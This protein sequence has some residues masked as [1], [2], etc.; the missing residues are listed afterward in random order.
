MGGAFSKSPYAVGPESFAAKSSS[1]DPAQWKQYDY[2]I[3][4]GGTAGCVLAS[5]LSED[6]GATVLLIEAGKSQGNL[7]SRIPLAFPKQ[8]RSEYDWDYVSVPQRHLNGN[9]IYSARGKL[10]GGTR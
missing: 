7:F 4:G 3:I 2:V 9:Q 5:R 1:D 10:L 8:Y 6:S